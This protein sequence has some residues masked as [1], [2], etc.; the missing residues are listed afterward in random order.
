MGGSTYS[1]SASLSLRQDFQNPAQVMMR[2]PTTIP[3]SRSA[4]PTMSSMMDMMVIC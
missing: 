3:A 2:A 1:Q 4:A